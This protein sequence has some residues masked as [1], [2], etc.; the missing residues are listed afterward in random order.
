MP[1]KINTLFVEDASIRMLVVS[2]KQIDKWA[3]TTLP[4]GLVNQGVI[5]DEAQVASRIKELFAQTETDTRK[6]IV[7][8]SGLNSLYRL[9]TLPELPKG[10]LPEAIMREAATAIPTP[11][12]E[13]YLSHQ[14]VPG[15][16][17]QTHIFLASFPRN[18]TDSLMRTLDKAGVEAN[19]MDLAPLALC[20]VCNEPRAIV[21]SAR[22]GRLDIMVMVERVPQ[23]IRSLPLPG[24]GSLSDNLPTIAEELQRTIDFYNSSHAEKPLEATIPLLVNGD[25]AAAPE[26]WEPLGTIVSH[27]VSAL[28]SPLEPREGFPVN[29][30]TVNIGLAL[31][32]FTL[33]REPA[34]F[35]LVNFNALPQVY[36]PVPPSPA[37]VLVP[38]AAIAGIGVLFY[39]TMLSRNIGA[40]IT[41]F[42]SQKAAAD[43]RIAQYEQ[44]ITR[45]KGQIQQSQ[46][47]TNL[48]K[49]TDSALNARLALLK[50]GR[51]RIAID[52]NE[53]IRLKPQGVI[54]SQISHG[55]GPVS[56]TANAPSDEQALDYARN[57]RSSGRFTSVHV[58]TISATTVSGNVTVTEVVT[59]TDNVTVS[60]N[61]TSGQATIPGFS[62][63]IT[64]K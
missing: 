34:N 49:A 42:N 35:S 24:E 33:E 51:D 23:I 37:R 22:P 12:E 2:G 25:L 4:P 50:K 59:I 30:Y 6:A 40:E 18:A 28:P 57:L 38:I 9:L 55:G 29:E 62:F 52:L 10:L 32:R 13:V 58:S 46:T 27:P 26:T 31:K 7:G 36:L 45:L 16:K 11:L 47:G 56:I 43:Q 60:S 39:L 48:A 5:T 64:L 14:P 21:V 54:V 8:L 17:G 20:R 53:I 1:Q 15:P 19:S 63:Q 3:S 41:G 61:V 44:D